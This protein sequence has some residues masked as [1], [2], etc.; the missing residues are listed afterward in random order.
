MRFIGLI[1]C[2]ILAGSAPA[3]ADVLV[4]AAASLKGPLDEIA[5]QFDDVTV[6][7][8]GSGTIAR[9]VSLGAPADVVILANAV[10]MEVLIEG[11]HVIP[12]SVKDVASNRLI[13]IGAAGSGEL[14]L[15]E[16]AF[17][18]RLGDGRLAV[19]LTDAVP[20]G[21]YA[22]ASLEALGLWGAVSDRLAEVDNVR[23]V[24]A[25]V[26]RGQ[27]P[28]GITY[29]TD[30]DVSDAVEEVAAFPAESHSPIRY[31]AAITPSDNPDTAAFLQFLSSDEGQ[32]HLTAAGFLPPQPEPI[33]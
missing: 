24:V 23:A 20:A 18:E 1:A 10:W 13:V 26:A 22:R 17:V 4:F 33:D 14:A 32:A 8:A 27:A 25:L 30:A 2:L 29:R 28:L 16:K 9:Q 15:T 6:S 7:Y 31:T 12:E 11:R 19:G 3:R 21:I 5:A